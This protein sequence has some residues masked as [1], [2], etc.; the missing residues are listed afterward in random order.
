MKVFLTGTSGYLG[1]A[2]ATRLLANGHDVHG[3]VRSP[4]AAD[5]AA[6]SGVTPRLGDLLDEAWLRHE[7]A[8]V[9][10]AIHAASPNDAGS[11]TFDNRILDTVLDVFAGTGQRYVHTGGSWIHGSGRDLNESSPVAPPRDRRL[12]PGG[13]R[14]NPRGGRCRT[15]DDGRAS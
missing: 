2:I 1:S 13:T 6:S 8:D 15:R 14:P 5:Q 11:A 12:A 10:G 7:L 9:D 3:H 4:E